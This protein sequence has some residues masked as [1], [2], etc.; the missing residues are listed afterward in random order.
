MK[1]FSNQKPLPA[2]LASGNRAEATSLPI[3]RGG[4]YFKEEASA[5]KRGIY[6]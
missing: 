4:P 2:A 6:E 3:Q 1:L 5:R